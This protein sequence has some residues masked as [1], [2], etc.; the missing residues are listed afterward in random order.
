MT[1]PCR[2]TASFRPFAAPIAWIARTKTSA[3]S[4]TP[5]RLDTPGKL[6]LYNNLG[7][8]EELALKIDEAVRQS[9]PDGWRGIQTRENIIK[10]ALWPLLNNDVAEVERI[11]LIIKAQREY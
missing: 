10:R 5:V 7:R 3:T 9:R 2:I 11:F 8:N 6:A 1:S 4:D